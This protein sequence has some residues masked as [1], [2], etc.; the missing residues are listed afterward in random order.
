M[1]KCSVYIAT[2]VDGFIARPNGE[3]DWLERPEYATSP[4]NG[5]TYEAFIA[6]VDALVMGRNTFEKVLTFGDWPYEGLSVVV[7]TSRPL[8]LPDALVGKV[9]ITAG[10]PHTIVEHLAA[11]GKQHLYIDGGATIQRFLQARL[12]DEITLTQIPTL[13]GS[14]IPLFGMTGLE[15]SLQL[16]VATASANGMVQVRYQ[17]IKD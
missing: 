15:Q 2:S 17:V 3:I 11:E 14:G 8:D 5:L 4:I 1:P 7:L 6:T 16:I 9:H 13:L 10:S 12:I